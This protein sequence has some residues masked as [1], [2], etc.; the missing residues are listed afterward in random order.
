[1]AD[2]TGQADIRGVDIQK[3]TR[4]YEMEAS[5]FKKYVNVIGTDKR[6]IRW[7]SSPFGILDTTD[8]T[9]MTASR[10]QSSQLAMP[11]VIGSSWT[12]NTSYIKKYIVESE[13]IS[14]ED[15][16]DSQVNILADTLRDLVAAVERQ[17]D[18]RIWNVMTESQSVV[19][20]NT[21]ASTAAWDAGSG[22]DPIED[23]MEAKMNIRIN[24]G[25]NPDDGG[26]LFLSP[27]DEKNLFV[28]LVSTKGA[29]I[30]GY[31]SGKVEDSTIQ[32]MLKLKVVVSNNVTADYAAVAIPDKAVDFY[33]FLPLTSVTKTEEG[34]GKKIRVWEEGEAV[35]V[36]PKCVNLISNTQA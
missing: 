17:V 12:R 7:Q 4:T 35:L 2:Q 13:W 9:G 28:W 31:S 18:A 33:Q 34:I 36:R 16:R 23:I 19:N 15:I 8:T 21:N 6:E 26:V 5:I 27:K 10:I 20:I 32:T 29:N 30:P 3:L 22:Q 11:E 25:F 1:M 14:E 24:S